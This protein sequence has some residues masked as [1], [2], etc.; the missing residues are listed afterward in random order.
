MVKLS[1][2]RSR[3]EDEDPSGAPAEAPAQA[4]PGAAK[5]SPKGAPKAPTAAA[6]DVPKSPKPALQ[7]SPAKAKAAKEAPKAPPAEAAPKTGATDTAKSPGKKKAPKT[8]AVEPELTAEATVGD[9]GHPPPE[10]EDGDGGR[11]AKKRRV[12]KRGTAASAAGEEEVVEEE[13]DGDGDGGGDE[14]GAGGDGSDSDAGFRRIN[15]KKK[16]EEAKKARKAAKGAKKAAKKAEEAEEAEAGVP[17]APRE[18]VLSARDKL[19]QEDRER[20]EIDPLGNPVEELIRSGPQWARQVIAMRKAIDARTQRR[21]ESAHLRDSRA[22]EPWVAR[23][24]WCL[25]AG[26]L[27]FHFFKYTTRGSGDASKSL[28]ADIRDTYWSHG[29]HLRAR[30]NV[31]L[32]DRVSSGGWSTHGPRAGPRALRRRLPPPTPSHAARCLLPP[33]PLAVAQHPPAGIRH[34]GCG[35]QDD[36]GRADHGAGG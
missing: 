24:D 32:K 36:G 30:D 13:G 22:R 9:D 33:R 5:G 31:D 27:R 25:L 1:G 14:Q 16:K 2:K 8:P 35:R 19:T 28:F 10:A 3:G 29:L 18:A 26:M 7:A 15:K 4:P 17:A 11:S 21:S 23:E 34:H 20:V 6:A 12:D